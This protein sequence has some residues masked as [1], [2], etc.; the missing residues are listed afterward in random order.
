MSLLQKLGFYSLLGLLASVAGPVQ[1]QEKDKLPAPKAVAVSS[2]PVQIIVAAGAASATPTR[3]GCVGFAHT[4]GGD[5]QVT[6]PAPHVLVVTMM[7]S[8]LAKGQL[9]KE[10]SAAWAFDMMQDFEIVCDPKIKN[11]KLTIEG[12]LIG[13]LLSGNGCCKDAVASAEVGS[14][15]ASITCAGVPVAGFDMPARVATCG[16][17]QIVQL[18]EGP[19]CNSVVP[20]CFTLH[21][22]LNLAAI[23]KKCP[24]HCKAVAAEFA[25]SH[26][27]DPAWIGVFD[28][29][30]G[31]IDKDFGYRVTIRAVPE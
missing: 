10:S 21:Q 8:A 28:P 24:L 31:T 16:D 13:S 19:I 1:G 25:P 11:V 3:T 22:T 27:M 30:H 7:G 17:K 29:F 18:R 5:I 14:A 12:R 4:G 20:G 23:V 26:A 9:L 15:H 2:A 6:Q